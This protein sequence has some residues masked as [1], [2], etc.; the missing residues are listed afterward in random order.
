MFNLV[1]FC[2]FILSSYFFT[3]LNNLLISILVCV[4]KDFWRTVITQKCRNTRRRRDRSLPV[5]E[6]KIRKVSAEAVKSKSREDGAQK[7]QKTTPAYGAKNYMPKRPVSEDDESIQKHIDFMKKEAKAR[8]R[9]V[10]AVETCMDLTLSDR[11]EFI[12]NGNKTVEE[13]RLQYPL[14]FNAHQVIQMLIIDCIHIWNSLLF[15]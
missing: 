10:R 2:K 6:E 1:C 12:I 11:R 3:L 14:L 5:V 9:N 8:S 15:K 7:L 13:V 4:S